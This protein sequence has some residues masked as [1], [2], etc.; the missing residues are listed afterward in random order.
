MSTCQSPLGLLHH[1]HRKIDELSPY[2]RSSRP[3]Y[4]QRPGSLS[5]LLLEYSFV[6]VAHHSPS[7]RP[8]DEGLDR[9]HAVQQ[10]HGIA[11]IQM[12]KVLALAI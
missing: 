8:S 10:L 12:S 9:H 4:R 3:R 6:L 11:R 2:S 5:D 7:P 1:I